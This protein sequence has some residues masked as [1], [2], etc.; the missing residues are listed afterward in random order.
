MIAH[1]Q[2]RE[3]AIQELGFKLEDAE[4]IALVAL[5]SGVF[6]RSQYGR[7]VGGSGST[8]RVRA[9]RM[10]EALQL[11]RYAE[12]FD[13]PEIGRV[14]RLKSRTVYRV[15]G[16]EHIRHRRSA[17]QST[18]L[19]RLLSLDF[20]L[21]EI[22]A[23]WLP[24]EAE[25][26]GAFES[27]GIARGILPK[28]V[29]GSSKSGR[30]ERPFGWK[31]PIAFEGGR[32]RF[33]FVDIGGETHE[34]M[35]SW[36]AEHALLWSALEARGVRVEAGAVCLCDQRLAEAKRIL[37]KWTERGVRVHAG[38]MSGAEL[39]EL[40][41]IE[42]ALA[43]LDE[44]SMAKWGGLDGTIKRGAELQRRRDAA[45]QAGPD[46]IR[47][48]RVQASLAGLGWTGAMPWQSSV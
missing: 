35:L 40:T 34:E 28:R 32:A 1:L 29:Y 26:V 39:D 16:A 2:G 18:L 9:L 7:F 19:R 20:V 46:R 37:V 14:C 15:L 27:L 42:R 22:G 10:V 21:G 45:E 12:E 38:R 48:D 11:R 33:V 30:T 17:A 4:W 47:L 23:P 44:G 8:A 6:L 3:K 25:K 36:G 5:H 24:T 13:M 31:M 43:S 41:V